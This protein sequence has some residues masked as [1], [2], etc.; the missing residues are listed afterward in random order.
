MNAYD[1]GPYNIGQYICI[2]EDG[3]KNCNSVNMKL[4]AQRARESHQFNVYIFYNIM[5]MIYDLWN[6]HSSYI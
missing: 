6:V 2:N 4:N 3:N 1:G 5:H